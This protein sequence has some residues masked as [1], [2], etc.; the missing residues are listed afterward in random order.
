MCV[1]KLQLL[2][3]HAV[4]GGCIERG[5]TQDGS[6]EIIEGVLGKERRNLG[7]DAAE[8]LVLIHQDSAVGLGDRVENGLFVER[9]DGAK[10]HDL[11]LNAMLGGQDL[12]RG[13]AGEDGPAVGDEGDI[14][15]LTLHFG[16]AERD[17]VGAIGN[18]SKIAVEESVLHEADG[19]VI[20]D[21]GNHEALGVIRSSG[22][23]DLEPR[24]VGQKILRGVRVGGTDVCAAI[25]GA[26]DDHRDIDQ[27]T[28]HV[29]DAAGVIDDLV[30]ADIRKA[31]EHELDHGAKTHHGSTDAKAEE[32]GLADRGVDHA[33]RSKT[34]PESLG[35]L[36][37]TVVLGDFLTHEEDILIAGELFGKGVV[38]SL[39]VGDDG[40]D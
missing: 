20:T 33:L 12:C 31:P 35:N 19:V 11:G 40:H 13:E 28:R 26:S 21:R 36:V 39:A 17:G 23:D 38:E 34:L 10:I 24:G 29:T 30:E 37:G 7:A 15:S 2:Q 5:D 32:G 22:A 18:F 25:S 14:Q 8:G 16:N 4:D 9:S 1:G 3:W 27:S 6:I